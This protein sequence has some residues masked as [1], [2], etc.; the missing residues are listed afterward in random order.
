M[1]DYD[2]RSSIERVVLYGPVFL[3]YHDERAGTQHTSFC[4]TRATRIRSEL[5]RGQ[6]EERGDTHALLPCA[7]P[8]RPE[9]V[10]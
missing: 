4:R 7:Y 1:V 6:E 8:S 3:L 5:R 9:E 10:E 2:A